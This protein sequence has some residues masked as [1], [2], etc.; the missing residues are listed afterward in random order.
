[1]ADYYAGTWEEVVRFVGQ[2]LS[3][4]SGEADILTQSTIEKFMGDIDEEIDSIL[5]QVYYVPLRKVKVGN[6]F[7][8]PDP[9]PYIAKVLTA[10]AILATYYKDVQP[11]ENTNI[12]ALKEEAFFRLNKLVNANPGEGNTSILR[13]Q[14]LKNRSRFVSPTI[15]PSKPTT[16]T[17]G[18]SGSIG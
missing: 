6:T 9:I 3:V 11:N 8:Y 7:V 1:M 5:S 14:R 10:T 15:V 4:G 2:T 12:R 17:S 13:G 16:P 18:P